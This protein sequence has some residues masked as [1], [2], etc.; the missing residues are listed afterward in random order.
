MASFNAQS[1]EFVESGSMDRRELEQRRT[2]TREP[3][4]V[5]TSSA[6][7]PRWVF[8]YVA[9]VVM[10]CHA[11]RADHFKATTRSP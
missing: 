7:L 1:G 11:P 9:L 10:L 2:G 6:E 5:G 3:L 4:V 8:A